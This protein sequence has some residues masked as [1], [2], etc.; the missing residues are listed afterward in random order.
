MHLYELPLYIVDVAFI[1][2]MTKVVHITMGCPQENTTFWVHCLDMNKKTKAVDLV[3]LTG[4]QGFDFLE[5]N[6]RS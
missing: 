5:K 6:H 3:L 2:L 1:A 4:I